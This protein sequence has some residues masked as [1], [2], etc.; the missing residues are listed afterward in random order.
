MGRQDGTD[1][2]PFD[3]HFE[4][5]RTESAKW[6]DIVGSIDDCFLDLS[7]QGKA[8]GARL[9]VPLIDEGDAKHTVFQR[10]GGGEIVIRAHPTDPSVLVSLHQGEHLS[11]CRQPASGGGDDDGAL[12]HGL[13]VAEHGYESP[14]Q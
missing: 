5:R 3:F 12:A 4:W 7:F 2:F 14:G 9:V 6:Q 11:V 10:R 1:A 8:E 13:E